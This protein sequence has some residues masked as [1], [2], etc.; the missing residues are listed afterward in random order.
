MAFARYNSHDFTLRTT[1][2]KAAKPVP[3]YLAF[4][5]PAGS[6]DPVVVPLGAAKE[7]EAAVADWQKQITQQAVS[8]DFVT[9][10]SES[11]YRKAGAT[12]R[13]RVWDPIGVKVGTSKSVFIIPD[14]ALHLVNFSSMPIGESGYLIERS[15]VIH[16]LSTERDLVPREGREHGH[17]LLALGAPAF[18]DTREFASLPPAGMNVV[19]AVPTATRSSHTRSVCGAFQSMHFKP[20]PGS[21][22]EIH[23]V[24]SLWFDGRNPRFRNA[25]HDPS[26]DAPVELEG[27]LATEGALKSQAHGKRVLHL[28]THAFFLHRWT[29]ALRPWIPRISASLLQSLWMILC[30]SQGLRSQEQIIAMPLRRTRRMGF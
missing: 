29:V 21:A 1:D 14:G 2:G 3:S 6:P 25:S 11:A 17:G 4:V 13:E 15:L 22:R 16:Y 19:S 18:D 12:L 8:A 7:I 9:R 23:E 20:L 28:A 10:S 5:L 26:T 30:Y 24:V 27:T